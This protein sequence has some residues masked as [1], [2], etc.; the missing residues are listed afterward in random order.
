[1][2]SDLPGALALGDDGPVGPLAQAACGGV[3]VDADDERVAFGAR[4]LEQRDV[5][6]MQ[7]V[8]DAVG[9]NDP[10]LSPPPGCGGLGRT[11]LRGSVQSGCTALG[12]KEKL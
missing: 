11:N 2:L 9:E 12:W 10:A 6:G 1:M 3:A 7:Q 5:A 4:R 8:K